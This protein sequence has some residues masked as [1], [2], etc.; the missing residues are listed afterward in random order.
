MTFQ[1][2]SVYDLRRDYCAFLGDAYRGG[3]A[4]Q[5]PSSQSYGTAVIR[6]FAQ[7]PDNAAAQISIVNAGERR[8]YLVPHAGE[9]P[10]EFDLRVKLA[11]YVNVCEPIVDS[12]RDAVVRHVTRDLG[13]L[14][15]ALKN[16]NGRGQTWSGLVNDV[17]T[18][19]LT[20]GYLPVVIDAPRTNPARNAAEEEALGIGLRAVVV[21]PQSIAWVDTDDDGCVN[22]FAWYERCDLGVNSSI[23]TTKVRVWNREEWYTVEGMADRT[24]L[25]RIREHAKSWPRLDQGRNPI[26]QVPV[27]WAF[28]NEDTTS[29]NPIGTSVIEDIAPVARTIF[30]ELSRVEEDHRKGAT[31]LA[32]PTTEASGGLSPD[33]EIRVGPDSAFGFA[34]NTAPPSYVSPPSERASEIRAHVLFLIALAYRMAGLEVAADSSAQVQSGEALRVRS[35]GFED[36]CGGFAQSLERWERAA[37]T[38]VAA[39]LRAKPTIVLSYPKR[40][41]LPDLG[42]DLARAVLLT[43]TWGSQLGQEGTIAVLRQAINAALSLSEDQVNRLID[44]IKS[45]LAQ[46]AAPQTPLA[47]PVSTSVPG[48]A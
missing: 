47:M 25:T 8:T 13:A 34:S 6:V 43:E 12:Y 38:L 46:E 9:V 23:Y 4:W 20:Y 11:T 32:V 45:K 2:L 37:L 19:A 1:A 26:G 21:H 10:D 42:E 36:R 24:G 22:E 35:R 48:G 28:F 18:W 27:T 39:W 14:D 30:N 41:V 5:N 15:N 40:F 3:W 31:F 7:A 44:E 29:R 33:T 17:A 16:L